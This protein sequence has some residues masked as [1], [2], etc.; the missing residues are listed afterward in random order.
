MNVLSTGDP[1]T[2]GS[3][4]R[5]CEASFGKDSPSAKFF[6]DKIA[7]QGADEPVIAA[8]S[9]MMVIVAELEKRK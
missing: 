5:L 7:E 2:L 3:Y 9:Q 4:L 8:E 1:S 6:R